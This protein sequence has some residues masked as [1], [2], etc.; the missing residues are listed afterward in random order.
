MSNLQEFHHHLDDAPDKKSRTLVGIVIALA[1]A[2]LGLYVYETAW[3]PT[4]H[5]VV[6]DS[7]LPAH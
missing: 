7:Q 3:N 5:S 4:T 1:M 6:A 2:G